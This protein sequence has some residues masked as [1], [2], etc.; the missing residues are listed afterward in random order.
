MIKFILTVCLLLVFDGSSYTD[1]G[2]SYESVFR[3]SFTVCLWVKPFNGHPEDEMDI[4]LGNK[5]ESR[6]NGFSFQIKARGYIQAVYETAG[7]T[8]NI[9]SEG[10]VFRDGVNDWTHLAFTANQRRV[11]LYVNGVHNRTLDCSTLDFSRYSC[12]HNIYI[13]C[14]NSAGTPTHFFAGEIKGVRIIDKAL[15]ARGMRRIFKER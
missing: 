1:T 15:S 4:M 5:D 10:R 6:N 9:L 2:R 7:N 14:R 8:V 13:G 3:D 12:P 11:S